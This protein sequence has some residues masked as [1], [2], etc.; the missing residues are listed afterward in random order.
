MAIDIPQRALD[1]RISGARTNPRPDNVQ[2]V[3]PKLRE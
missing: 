2:D 1:E 3:L